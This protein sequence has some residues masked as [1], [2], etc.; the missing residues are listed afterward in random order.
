[1]VQH[2]PEQQNQKHHR[3]DAIGKDRA[4]KADALAEELQDRRF[5]GDF[6]CADRLVGGIEEVCGEDHLPHAK[7]HDEGRKADIGHQKAVD[8]AAQRARGKAEQ[9]GKFGGK[10]IAKG[11]LAHY[12]RR[13]HHDGADRKI[14]TCG[15][16]HKRLRHGNDAGDGDLLQNEGQCE[17]GEELAAKRDAEHQQRQ[18]EHDQRHGSGIVMQEIPHPIKQRLVARIER[19]DISR[20]LRQRLFIVLH[21]RFLCS[22]SRL[23]LTHVCLLPSPAERSG[24]SSDLPGPSFRKGI[25]PSTCRVRSS[26]RW[27]ER[28]PPACR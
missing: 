17:G 23:W 2:I 13:Q 28:L 7:R 8:E 22:G 18:N 19:G 27:T 20:A 14:D 24:K 15:Q 3:N 10:P 6:L 21:R 16:D 12:H 11:E 5:R 26:C 4:A 1:M 9:N 25:S